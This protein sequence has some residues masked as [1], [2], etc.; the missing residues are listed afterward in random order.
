MYRA[1]SRLIVVSGLEEIDGFVSD[2]I[3]QPVFLCDT[4]RPAPGK[5]IFKWFGLSKAFEWIS[6]DCFNQIED[7]DCNAT[8]AFHPKPEVLRNSG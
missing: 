3:H 6:H 5:H 1:S 7:S 2:A 4:P 8:L